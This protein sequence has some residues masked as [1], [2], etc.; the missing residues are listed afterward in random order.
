MQRWLK[1]S[2]YLPEFGFE[3]HIYT[4]EN[5]HFN[6]KDPKLLND[7]HENV[8]VIKKPIWEPYSIANFISGSKG[9]NQGIVT[10]K[11]SSFKPR[12]LNK[13]RANYFIPDPRKFWVKPS[14]KFLKKYVQEQGIDYVVSTGPPHSMHLIALGLKEAIPELKWLVDIRDPWSQFDF[15]RNFGASDRALNKQAKLENN[16]LEQCDK[17]IATSYQMKDLM[18]DFDTSKF[19]CITNGYDADDFQDYKPIDTP[20][21]MI[22]YHAGLLNK[23]RNPKRLW[24]ALDTLCASDNQVDRML[25]IHLVGV[26]DG[27]IVEQIRSYD[28]LSD[29]LKLETYKAHE[30][31]ISDYAKA[32][33]LLLLVNN[34]DNSVANIPGKLFEYIASGKSI[35]IMS[36]TNTDAARIL[37]DHPSTMCLAY[38]EEIDL[39]KLKDF[40]FNAE[41]N[42]DFP[43][44]YKEGFERKNLTAKLVNL[45]TEL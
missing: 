6:V 25:R 23:V 18:V 4:P 27:D 24:K 15:L 11:K 9:G 45:L 7:I 10:D 39:A 22:I 40:L 21:E 42:F 31:V 43:V 17:V 41:R 32:D 33:S 3:P 35:L 28:R 38:D 34:T 13:I 1:F 44:G 8:V 30:D 16:V 19:E 37:N 36:E 29:K 5:P 2:K 20:G 12:I 14:I 26:V